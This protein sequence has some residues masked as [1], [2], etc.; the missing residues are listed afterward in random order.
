VAATGDISFSASHRA[1]PSFTFSLLLF[2]SLG[3]FAFLGFSDWARFG[4]SAGCFVELLSDVALST[5]AWVSLSGRRLLRAWW[6]ERS[7][8]FSCLSSAAGNS[9]G[10]LDFGPAELGVFGNTSVA[11]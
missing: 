3:L 6:L 8:D 9:L 5:F 7:G 4:L 2:D 1:S 11:D 10:R